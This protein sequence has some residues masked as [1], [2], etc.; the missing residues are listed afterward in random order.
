M[1]NTN[2]R[3]QIKKSLV[4]PISKSSIAIAVSTALWT[5]T[6]V[7]ATTSSLN[8][9]SVN[10]D[11]GAT[12]TGVGD[13]STT[14]NVTA[15]TQNTIIDW[16]S[17][18]LADDETINF[19]GT[20]ESVFLNRVTGNDASLLDG[21][22]NTSNVETLIFVNPNGVTVGSN[23]NN[24]GAL[25]S[26]LMISTKD[27]SSL[28]GY[29]QDSVD[30][31]LTLTDSGNDADITINS[32]RATV[33]D[34]KMLNIVSE[35]DVVIS[36]SGTGT[37]TLGANYLTITADGDVDG[38]AGA[39]AADGEISISAG[40]NVDIESVKAGVIYIDATGTVS[41]DQSAGTLEIGQV[42]GS[43]IDLT[44]VQ[45]LSGGAVVINNPIT[46]TTG[47]QTGQN[48]DF[49]DDAHLITD[50]TITISASDSASNNLEIGT[51]GNA[52]EI[53][54]SDG[55][56][57]T[58]G[59]NVGNLYFTLDGDL[60][61]GDVTSSGDIQ[62]SE[63]SGSTSSLTQT[64]TLT[65]NK[66]AG[67]E[68]TLDFAGVDVD[69][70]DPTVSNAADL[71][72]K[73]NDLTIA[74]TIDVSGQ[75]LTLTTTGAITGEGT[76]AS[77]FTADTLV[78]TGT[79]NSGT[80]D[81]EVDNLNMTQAGSLTISNDGDL[82]LGV[83]SVNG[84]TSITTKNAGDDIT[85]GNAVTIA[86]S[87][88]LSLATNDTTGVVTV[89]GVVSGA[90]G[91]LDITSDNVDLNAAIT[92]GSVN[93]DTVTDNAAIDLGTAVGTL[94]L[95]ASSVTNL[96]AGTAA[97]TVTIGDS[98]NTGAVT[99]NSTISNT[100]VDLVIN[101]G[102]LTIGSAVTANSI[103][104]DTVGTAD[105][106][107]AVVTTDNLDID[108]TGNFAV[109]ATGSIT[110]SAGDIIVNS[111]GTITTDGALNA[112]NDLTLTADGAV[113]TNQTLTAGNDTSISTTTGTVTID[114]AA[115]STGDV[116]ISTSDSSVTTTAKVS[117]ADLTVTSSTGAT[118]I[119][120]VDSAAI[121]AGSGDISVTEDDALAL[122]NIVTTSA[123]STAVTITSTAGG[124]TS[125]DS[126]SIQASSGEIALN[127]AADIDVNT[128]GAATF[129]SLSD[130]VDITIDA[131]TNAVTFTDAVGG[132]D[133]VL[134]VDGL[135]VQNATDLNTGADA[136]TVTSGDLTLSASG[137]LTVAGALTATDHV[138]LQGNSVSLAAVTS[139]S[140]ADA[141]GDILIEAGA[142]GLALNANVTSNNNDMD[143]R[144]LADSNTIGLGNG[145]GDVSIS[146]G[147]LDLLQAGTG[148]ITFGRSTGGAVDI[149]GADLTTTTTH[150][151]VDILSAGAVSIDNALNVADDLDIESAS[152]SNSG[153]AVITAVDLDVTTTGNADLSG[154]NVLSG[155][156]TSDVSGN[157]TLTN[158]TNTTLGTT[159]AAN[160]TLSSNGSVTDAGVIS[161]TGTT[162]IDSST[163]NG[164]VDLNNNTHNLATLVVDAGTGTLDVAETDALTLQVDNAGA[165][166][167]DSVGD[168]TLNAGT[169]T[170]L[171]VTAANSVTD[172]G[173]L[174][175]SGTTD[176]DTSAANGNIDLNNSTHS[177]ATLVVD[178][179]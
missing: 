46:A 157:L 45:S 108:A 123:N 172:A 14:A 132:G 79:T 126:T 135:D 122:N 164:N 29:D 155:T 69:D 125:N 39:I 64:G 53:N 121:N 102:N 174:T 37:D 27:V 178:A 127:A 66:S 44:S 137:T 48:T 10:S 150:A 105:V 58:S 99:I 70:L 112:A 6:T 146:Q 110:S 71:T 4:Q 62:I 68:I 47:S 96:T 59:N 32:I 92:A 15:T 12:I 154:N 7:A 25:N 55:T 54:S 18:G 141:A 159:S 23:F 160:L 129:N 111:D 119:T 89:N 11:G 93:L 67:Q 8:D 147:E 85:L 56:L 138:T 65:L 73:S 86:D 168:L 5:S 80:F 130:G 2:N 21:S 13:G 109:S 107:A 84:S 133:D 149:D 148:V 113:D 31:G 179:G 34:D 171:T 41:V 176:I 173:A 63:A 114:A 166:T 158:T 106:N 1:K 51:N 100:N 144:G 152:V 57:T 131:N 104:T 60:N 143:V 43:S 156:I 42:E 134:T 118:L 98:S 142:G 9:S 128:S 49:S 74:D 88:S 139:D 26:N 87:A 22:V 28:A 77:D 78:I 163:A 97:Q 140:D 81:T 3:T 82:V 36:N 116:T 19:N 94:N 169:M 165:V 167:L 52:I 101:S 75:T 151:G 35:N 33:N 40:G 50:G 170:G 61:V 145:V 72:I 124:I 76:S 17:L 103:D 175:V 20:T 117:G 153:S 38:S 161:V 162:D 83:A 91:T 95:D 115:T 24:T 90:S 120:A 30:F 16:Q 177:L 136:I